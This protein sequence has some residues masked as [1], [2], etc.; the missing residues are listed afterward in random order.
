MLNHASQVMSPSIRSCHTVR[1][2]PFSSLV[3]N[4]IQ[5]SLSVE[6][7]GNGGIVMVV[8]VVVVPVVVVL[9]IVV[10]VVVVFVTVTVVDVDVS[11]VMVTV[12][13]VDV[14]VVEV[15][16]VVLVIVL[17][18]VTVL[19]VVVVIVDV[20]VGGRTATNWVTSPPTTAAAIPGSIAISWTAASASACNSSHAMNSLPSSWSSAVAVLLCGTLI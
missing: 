16:V 4:V 3:N 8:L 9:V 13:V 15:R 19:M 5:A 7:T 20:V 1:L 10:D 6:K 17:V 12:R 18:L 2:L 11:V 14:C